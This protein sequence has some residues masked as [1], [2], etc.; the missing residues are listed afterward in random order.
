[1]WGLQ[2]QGSK[3][4]LEHRCQCQAE[5]TAKGTAAA[6]LYQASRRGW[7]PGPEG[8]MS[9]STLRTHARCC[10]GIIV[11]IADQLRWAGAG[12]PPAQAT[13]TACDRGYRIGASRA[14]TRE[15]K[16][17]ASAVTVCRRRHKQC[18]EPC[19]P[20]QPWAT[21]RKRRRRR[22]SGES[23]QQ[24]CIGPQ[25]TLT[26]PCKHG[27]SPE[28][29]Q[30]QPGPP[31]RRGPQVGCCVIALIHPA[32]IPAAAALRAAQ[33]VLV[34]GRH[35][36]GQVQAPLCTAPPAAYASQGVVAMVGLW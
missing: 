12:A 31:A 32:A 30:P 25:L 27:D 21:P 1:M 7:D 29:P 13:I 3:A 9:R 20:G 34:P 15:A 24:S 36:F 2:L 14:C 23:L 5:G 22:P 17:N 6:D 11:I 10:W 35:G 16:S 4:G 33:Q 28:E 26:H 19:T 8:Y 18:S